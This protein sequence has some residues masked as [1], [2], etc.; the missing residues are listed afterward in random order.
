MQIF[1]YKSG[2]RK[3]MY[4]F[5]LY[6]NKQYIVGTEHM[7]KNNKESKETKIQESDVL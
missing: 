7:Q 1:A 4:N 3:I 5:I 2:C 6:R